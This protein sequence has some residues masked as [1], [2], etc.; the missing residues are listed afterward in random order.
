MHKYE[1]HIKIRKHFLTLIKT[2][3]VNI[4]LQHLK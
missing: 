1:N 4:R 2:N 3:K